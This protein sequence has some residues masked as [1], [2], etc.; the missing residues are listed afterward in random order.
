MRGKGYDTFGSFKLIGG[1]A[2]GHPND[3]ELGA[4][5]DFFENLLKNI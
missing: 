5:V 1:V 4:A 2:K 3:K